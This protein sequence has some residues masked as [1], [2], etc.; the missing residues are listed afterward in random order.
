VTETLSATLPGDV[1]AM[2]HRVL[3]TACDRELRLATAESCTGGLLA[4]VLTDVEGVSHAFER[5]FVVYT[6]EAKSQLLG[7]SADLI[8]RE[9]VVSRP[10]AIAMAEGGIAH[11]A[12]D[13]CLAVT[14][15]SGPAGPDDEPGLVHFACQRRGRDAQHREEHFGDIGRGATR[16]ACL[17]VALEM[18]EAQLS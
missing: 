15:F 7:V 12:A 11:S 14:G 9:G 4:S 3:Q 13:I 2:V 6:D 10:V 16:I 5:G 17:R 8:D 1:E 18:I